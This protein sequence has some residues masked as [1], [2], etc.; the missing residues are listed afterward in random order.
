[1]ET[2][3]KRTSAETAV[4]TSYQFYFST[5]RSCK[6]NIFVYPSFPSTTLQSTLRGY[7]SLIKL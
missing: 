3:R 4:Q 5:L 2:D 6:S 7:Y 1:M